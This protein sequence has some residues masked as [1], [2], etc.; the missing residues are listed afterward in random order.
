VQIVTMHKSK[1]LQYDIVIAPFLWSARGAT[2]K[3]SCV[4]VHDD[5]R[6]VYD[7]GSDREGIDAGNRRRGAVVRGPS[8]RIRCDDA[9][10]HRCYVVWA[11]AN[12][13]ERSALG[14]C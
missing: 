8:P 14:Y 7:I 1:G 9:C 2:S 10:V 12:Y 3:G 13:A 11:E 4:V 6:I 5:G